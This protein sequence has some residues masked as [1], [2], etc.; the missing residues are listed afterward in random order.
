MA[1][2]RNREIV[3]HAFKTKWTMKNILNIMSMLKELKLNK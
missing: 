3:C 2:K 1:E